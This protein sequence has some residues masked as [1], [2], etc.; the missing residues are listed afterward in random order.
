MLDTLFLPRTTLC[1]ACTLT[2]GSVVVDACASDVGLVADGNLIDTHNQRVA[3][4]LGHRHRLWSFL[5]H[6]SIILYLSALS[7]G[8]FSYFWLFS[9]TAGYVIIVDVVG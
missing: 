5:T 2:L 8:F 7:S 6:G 1:L 4:L 9:L 3:F